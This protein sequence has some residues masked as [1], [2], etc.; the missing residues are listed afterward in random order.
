MKPTKILCTCVSLLVAAAGCAFEKSE[1]A[2][3]PTI[4]GPIAGVE[5][6]PP[7]PL[8]P[9][10]GAQIPGDRQPITLL[11]ENAASNGQRP[12]N[13][14][15]EVA[16]DPNFANK[17]FLREGVAPGSNGRTSL[18]LTDPL[19]SGRGYFWRAKAQDGANSG[20]YSVAANFDIYT[21]LAF[22]KPSPISPTNNEKVE[23][24]S[25][26]FR[27]SNAPR[28]GSTISPGYSLEV[29]TTDSFASKLVAWQFNEQPGQTTVQAASPL[30]P[31]I[32]LFWRVRAID[33]GN[34]GPWSNTQ[35][36]QTPAPVVVAPTPSPSPA[37]GGSC[38]TQPSHL[39]V[40]KCRRAQ[41]GH[42]DPSQLNQFLRAVAK[43]LNNGNFADG[44][45]GILVKTSGNN[46]LGYSCDIICASSGRIWDALADSDGAQDPIWFDK[47][48]SSSTCQIQH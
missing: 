1:N 24:T 23:T 10:A 44:P 22:D 18:R 40:V 5:I 34:V 7:K 43:D 39:D 31:G 35:V 21:P 41:Y 48:S 37:P 2:L 16:S 29:A 6:S 27:W 25:P 30:P 20:P 47:G 3:S 28:V 45:F 38:Q 46:C 14:T 19:G 36:F 4:A 17:V 42:M 32:Q 33:G 9:S 26:T 11:L 8:E 12:L 15:F 13:Y